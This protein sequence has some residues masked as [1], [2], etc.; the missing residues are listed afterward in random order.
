MAGTRR[1]AILAAIDEEPRTLSAIAVSLDLRRH[2]IE[3]ELPHILRSARAAGAT[4]VVVPARCRACGFEFGPGKLSKPSR[5]PSCKSA[6]LDE[7]MLVK[8][9]RAGG[10]L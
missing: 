6:W 8:H 3:I 7:P 4:V 1:Q 10:A 2:D 9:G 5:C